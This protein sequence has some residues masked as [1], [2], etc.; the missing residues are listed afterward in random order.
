[1]SAGA[2][3]RESSDGHRMIVVTAPEDLTELEAERLIKEIRR[4]IDEAR[5]ANRP[6]KQ[7]GE[8]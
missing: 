2:R 1:M 4:A 5:S 8:Y 7:L 3:T 6:K